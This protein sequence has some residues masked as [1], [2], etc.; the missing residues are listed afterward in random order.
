MIISFIFCNNDAIGVCLSY[1]SM[2]TSTVQ[3]KKPAAVF[4]LFVL[5]FICTPVQFY[6]NHKN[7]SKNIHRDATVSENCPIC[8]HHYTAYYQDFVLA[9]VTDFHPK[10]IQYY[11]ETKQ[12]VVTPVCFSIPNKS[13][14]VL[15]SVYGYI[16]TY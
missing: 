6:H 7:S 4:M 15:H 2:L 12:D 14:P 1:S 10:F 9:D 16:S 13:P 8:N 5:M 3:Y 11:I